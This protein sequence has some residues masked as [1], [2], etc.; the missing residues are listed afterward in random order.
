MCRLSSQARFF[1]TFSALSLFVSADNTLKEN[2][3]AVPGPLYVCM[4]VYVYM[5]VCVSAY[6]CM[7]VYVYACV[8]TYT[9]IYIYIC[10]YVCIHFILTLRRDHISI[11]DGAFLEVC[12]IL[13]YT[14]LTVI[15]RGR[16][17]RSSL[18]LEQIPFMQYLYGGMY[19]YI[20]AYTYTYTYIHTYTYTYTLVLTR[21]HAYIH[22]YTHTSMRT[23]KQT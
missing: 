21:V 17:H 6:A 1:F 15:V 16:V 12:F 20:H 13:M 18:A 4:Y 23:Q 22:G 9:Y 8:F 14:H 3:I 7:C 19:T 5:Y 11:S 10:M 2:S